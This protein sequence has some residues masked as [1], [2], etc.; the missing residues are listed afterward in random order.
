MSSWQSSEVGVQMPR[1]ERVPECVRSLGDDAID[2]AELAGLVLDPWQKYALRKALGVDG[3]GKWA[4]YEVAIVTQRQN[5]K[6]SIL[7]AMQ[8]ASLFLWNERTLIHSAQEFSTAEESFLRIR[9]LI[10]GSNILSS[11][12]RRIYT[13]N[14][15]EAIEL[16][17]GNRLKFKAR[18]NKSARGFTADRIIF[19]EALFL[20][21]SFMAAVLP[22]MGARS[23]E[24][25]P[26]IWYTSSTGLASS[27]VLE[28]LRNRGITGENADSL[29]YLEW[30]AKSWDDMSIEERQAWGDDR[31]VWRADPE[32]WRAANP[33]YRVRIAPS[34][35][36]HE[37][38]SPMTDA[39]FEREHLGVWEKIGGDSLIPMDLWQKAA[40][41]T[42]KPGEH[43]VFA[44]DVPPSREAAYI[45]VASISEN[46]KYHVELVD[47]A[48]GL[49]WI[50]PRL[51][52]LEEKYS[53]E[54][55]VVDAAS[56]AGSL[57]PELKAN[58]VRTTQLSGRDYAK[59]CGQFYDAIR[60]GTLVHLD[61]RLL[62]EAVEAGRIHPIGDSLWKW[63]RKNVATN[64]SP[65]VAASLA[66]WGLQ[67]MEAKRLA[68]ANRKR[69]RL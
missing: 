8:L 27:T 18:S 31:D 25:N 59:A 6:G 69:V 60:Q 1:I 29:C 65:L 2:I 28:T 53:P 24:G 56:A 11:K 16:K 42:S 30:S 44:L 40:D 61:D 36:R 7:E 37:L 3:E 62:N 23:E 10:E 38:D 51:K 17:N 12:V 52:E 63:A 67:Y 4:A 21:S 9:N 55:I 35:F 47:T 50:V 68:R 46:G 39:E 33:S 48:E 45:A 49:A 64:I 5:G 22:A 57:L 66:L 34:Y 20:P 15:K 19:D 32:V 13:A 58:R 54:M 14:G 26:Q 43:M 41:E